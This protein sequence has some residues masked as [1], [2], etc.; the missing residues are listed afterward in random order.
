MID[1][2]SHLIYDVDDGSRSIEESLNLFKV[3]YNAGVK[4]MIL[5]PHYITD[6][7]Y[8]SSKLDNINKLNILKELLKQNN[9][10][11]NIYLGNEIYMDRNIDEMIIN[12]QAST[13][14]NTNYVL[15][16]L[17]MSGI[18][19]GYEDIIHNLKVK[20]YKV[21]LAHPERYI[22]FQKD[23]NKVYELIDLGV[24]LQSNYGSILGDYGLGS[25]K[26]VKRLM[27]EHLITYMSSDIHRVRHS[28]F[29]NRA[30]TKM[31]KYYTEEEIKD[32]VHN[33]AKALIS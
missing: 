23:I 25:K 26:L 13:L 32:L 22:S 17:P 31:K 16:E 27:K 14:N 10:D 2:H 19:Q 21:I 12:N 9:I 5:T 29:I 8:M 18:Y 4:D 15:I 7:R 6:S 11:M 24:E 28:D 30:I 33:N 3:M 20:G 1:I